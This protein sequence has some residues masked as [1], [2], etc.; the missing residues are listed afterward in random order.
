MSSQ[1]QQYVGWGLGGSECGTSVLWG[2]GLSPSPYGYI[3]PSGSSLNPTLLGFYGDFLTSAWSSIQSISS[4]SPLSGGWGRGK[5]WTFLAA[6]PG[7][8]FL[9]TSHPRSPPRVTSLRQK[10]LP[11]LLSLRNFYKALRGS[12]WGTGGRDQH[13]HFFLFHNRGC[14]DFWLMCYNPQK[15]LKWSQ[16]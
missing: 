14:L 2:W 12:V 9:V 1:M 11:V 4:P 3:C 13:M 6:N 15:L 10:K 7:L 8:I 5:G 16:M